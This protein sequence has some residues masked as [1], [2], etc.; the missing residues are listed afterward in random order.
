[1]P[2]EQRRYRAL[3]PAL[4]H[5]VSGR[6]L[7]AGV[8]TG[9]NMPFYPSGAEV[10]GIDL[11]AAMLAHAAR[12][13]ARLGTRAALVEMDVLRTGFPDA[14]FDAIIS[15]FLFCVLDETQQLPALREL[16]RI[17]KPTGEIRLLE[18]AYSQDPVRRAIMRLWAPWV[19]FAYGATFDRNTERYVASAGLEIV[20]LRFL[21]RDIVKLIIARPAGL[22]SR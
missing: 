20:E 10:V 22:S 19:R 6:V 15:T 16:R 17:L 3:R 21:Y 8:G 11:S 12:R 4:F 2:F 14:S 5:G 1:M 18:Y 7:D 13:R 9:R